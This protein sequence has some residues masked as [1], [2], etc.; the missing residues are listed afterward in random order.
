[1]RQLKPGLVGVLLVIAAWLTLAVAQ[2]PA[3]SATV[4]LFEG[5]RLIAGDGG[6]PIENSAFLVENHTFTRVG[7]RGEIQAPAGAARIDLT[8]KTV[9]PALVDG[10]SHIGYMKNMTSGAQNYTRD[11]IL[12]HMRRF[13]YFGVA[14]SQAMGTD[15]GE[16]P[17]QLRDEILAGKHPDA[18]RFLSAGRGLS[19]LE[20]ISPDN[21]RQAAFPITTVAGA[22]ASVQELVPRHL[23]LIKTW[24]D[25]R[26]GAVKKLAP[27]L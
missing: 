9:I 7:R 11:N 27:E 8:G 12:D 3:P 25:D 22:R 19:P 26:G 4:M 18:A 6:A 16:M 17:F 21:M 20:E 23:Q 14:A 1:M 5:A 13:A 2:R 10:N 15:F 24:V